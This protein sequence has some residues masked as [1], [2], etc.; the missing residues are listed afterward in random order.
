[1]C[2]TGVDAGS[3]TM[4]TTAGPSAT[5]PSAGPSASTG[6]A[7]FA[8]AD[9]GPS[10]P[11]RTAKS[12]LQQMGAKAKST[13]AM[14]YHKEMKERTNFAGT[15][16]D[17]VQKGTTFMT[18]V[19]AYRHAPKW[20][21]GSKGA[22]MFSRTNVSP[23]PGSYNQPPE[24]KW[25]FKSTG[26]FSFGGAPRFGLGESPNKKAPGPGGYNPEDPN[27]SCMPKI[28]FGTSQ[29][30]RGALVSQA[31]PGPGAY[32]SKTCLGEGRMFTARGRQATSYMRARSLP[33]PGAY[34]PKLEAAYGSGPKTGFGTST[35]DDVGGAL[36]S[37]V[38]PGPGSYEM[39]NCKGVG[40]DGPMF[41][42]TSRRRLHD[43]SS[44]MTPGPGTYNSHGTS[45]GY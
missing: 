2:S 6:D 7:G 5:F 4:T 28:G 10:S 23:A 18:S 43:L 11:N 14:N 29:R 32:E 45:F 21:I 38:G 3:S 33:G 30:G 9:S 13:P 16:V 22:D 19:S 41:S 20:T 26:L 25:K 42:A 34:N 27:H 31:N 36:R 8:I 12:P 44:Y 17:G 40:Q 39:Q 24:D 37:L 1:V 35:R 15:T